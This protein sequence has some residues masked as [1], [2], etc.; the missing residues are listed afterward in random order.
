MD[1]IPLEELIKR[2]CVR[3]RSTSLSV[4]FLDALGIR[5]QI[6]SRISRALELSTPKPGSHGAPVSDDIRQHR[7]RKR[8]E[9]VR[10]F[11]KV[12][13][14]VFKEKQEGVP[15]YV[16]SA[17][18]KRYHNAMQQAMNVD[19]VGVSIDGSNIGRRSRLAGCVMNLHTS[20]T[21]W[22]PPLVM[23]STCSLNA[24]WILLISFF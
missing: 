4:Q 20:L 3:R 17:I 15:G 16:R 23:P 8:M 2:I 19:M 14:K 22:M 1:G 9:L 24:V 21:G 12:K 6:G 7:K 18:A 5:F 10:T 11:R 13:R